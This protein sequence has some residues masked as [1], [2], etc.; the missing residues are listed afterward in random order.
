MGFL[1]HSGAEVFV[2]AGFLVLKR[3]LEGGGALATSALS[4]KRKANCGD[5]IRRDLSS[6]YAQHNRRVDGHNRCGS[7]ILD[8]MAS[9]C[10]CFG[11]GVAITPRGVM[12]KNRV[13]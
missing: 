7:V 1:F 6:S 10:Q 2:L 5:D 12:L 3:F 13:R 8:R 4:R 11:S 9:L